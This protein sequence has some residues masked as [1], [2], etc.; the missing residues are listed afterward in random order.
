MSVRALLDGFNMSQG[1]ESAEQTIQRIAARAYAETMP[2]A[3]AQSGARHGAGA[4]LI[5]LNPALMHREY[6]IDKDRIIIGRDAES[7]TIVC[8]GPTISRQHLAIATVNGIEYFLK[9]ARNNAEQFLAFACKPNRTVQAMEK[10]FSN[11]ALNGFYLIADSGSRHI[12]A[13]GRFSE[14]GVLGGSL[15]CNEVI[16]RR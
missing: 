9:A 14:I 3:S 16:E 6:A 13:A 15:E 12:Q 7:C 8:S 2:A 11:E 1:N 4:F 5:A 10:R